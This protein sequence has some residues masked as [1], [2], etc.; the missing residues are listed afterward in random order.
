[1]GQQTLAGQHEVAG[2]AGTFAAHSMP[3]LHV[4][5]VLQ[6]RLFLLHELYPSLRFE[7][8]AEGDGIRRGR[9]F[10]PWLG[11]VTPRPPIPNAVDGSTCYACC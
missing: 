9:R 11:A 6:P 4:E 8:L 10:R 7:L 2:G 1:M 3:A 5:S